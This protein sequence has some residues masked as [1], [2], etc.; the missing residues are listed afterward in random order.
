MQSPHSQRRL[1]RSTPDG[2]RKVSL[3]DH[4][5]PFGD[6]TMTKEMTRQ[7]LYEEIKE[8]VFSLSDEKLVAVA[9][10]LDLEVKPMKYGLFEVATK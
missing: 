9:K 5:K 3:R 10:T 6:E 8:A 2:S 1:K 7:E 4:N